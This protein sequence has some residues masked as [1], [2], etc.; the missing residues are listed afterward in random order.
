MAAQAVRQQNQR[1][2]EI[3]DQFASLHSLSAVATAIQQS[4]HLELPRSASSSSASFINQH[5]QPQQQQQQ[6]QQH[7]RVN[8]THH[9]T[10]N[11]LDL[12][13]LQQSHSQP[14]QFSL[15]NLTL[16]NHPASVPS[17]LTS[18]T[19]LQSIP[20]DLHRMPMD[21]VGASGATQSA[22]MDM[23]RDSLVSRL[24]PSAVAAA[25]SLANDNNHH[26][27]PPPSSSFVQFVNQTKGAAVNFATGIQQRAAGTIRVGKRRG[28][29]KC[30]KIYGMAQRQLWCTQCKWKKACSRFFGTNHQ[31]G[32]LAGPCCAGPMMQFR[33]TARKSGGIR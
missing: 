24:A 22:I 2:Q 7:Q 3:L 31:T 18:S 9:T 30:R 13:Q 21:A 11:Q 8:Q 5:H 19:S 15:A 32:H 1:H 27:Q 23:V 14:L 17:S 20:I 33:P 4:H 10:T 26:H 25:N 12:A 28:S 16:N 6:Q 29:R